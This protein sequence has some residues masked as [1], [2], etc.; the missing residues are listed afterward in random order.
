MRSRKRAAITSGETAGLT[1]AD[2][3]SVLATAT[4]HD[5]ETIVAELRDHLLMGMATAV[6]DVDTLAASIDADLTG[7]EV[8]QALEGRAEPTLGQ[9]AEIM[10]VIETRKR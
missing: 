2:G 10:A 4:A 3:A 5:R 7:Q 8:Q 6:I 9:L 1:L